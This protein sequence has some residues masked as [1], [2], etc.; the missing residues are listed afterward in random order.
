MIKR[1]V[2][3]PAFVLGAALDLNKIQLFTPRRLS[4]FFDAIE[5]EARIFRIKLLLRALDSSAARDPNNNLFA[6]G[7]GKVQIAAG[8][9]S[10][11][12]ARSRSDG[13]VAPYAAIVHV[14]NA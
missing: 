12:D 7:R 13:V 8:V 9:I 6:S 5:T 10:V 4:L 3:Q 1:R 2:K 11:L 14:G